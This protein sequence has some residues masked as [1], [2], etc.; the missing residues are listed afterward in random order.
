MKIKLKSALS[1]LT[2]FFIIMLCCT[3]LAFALI[4]VNASSHIGSYIYYENDTDYTSADNSTVVSLYKYEKSIVLEL[5]NSDKNLGTFYEITGE[6]FN[7]V[8][9]VDFSDTVKEGDKLSV[10]F[11]NRFVGDGYCRD[12]VAISF[13]NDDGTMTE[14]LT[15]ETGKSNL[16]EQQRTS[17]KIASRAMT[18]AGSALG[19]FAIGFAVTLLISRKINSDERKTPRDKFII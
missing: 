2:L 13:V 7:I 5:E 19:F 14:F 3:L 10:T 6:N 8:N 11:A 4:A 17:S 12:I 18:V 9:N 1:A 15:Y 16:I